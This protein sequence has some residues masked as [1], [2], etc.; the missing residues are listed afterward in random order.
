MPP[1][2]IA[3]QTRYQID[4]RHILS[5]TSDDSS[6]IAV[7]Q[8]YFTKF[9]QKPV[10][11]LADDDIMLLNKRLT[12]DG[13]AATEVAGIF[14]PLLKLSTRAKEAAMYVLNFALEMEKVGKEYFEKL[15]SESTLPGIKNI[16]GM[17][18]DEQQQLYDTF[19]SLQSKVDTPLLVDSLALERAI[20]VFARIFN[21]A[22]IG[23]LKNDLDAYYHAMKIEAEIVTF[24]EDM[25]QKETNDDAR[26]LLREIAAEE[27]KLYDTI[28]TI[29]DFVA[30]PCTH[31][32]WGEFSNLKEL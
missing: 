18:A 11:L 25:A 16:F 22:T 21:E 23:L 31:L 32:A 28:E 30:A 13:D 2:K 7:Y 24:F 4:S 8:H 15:A 9:L 3:S 6:Q 20:D 1:W 12:C 5:K 14:P 29:H 27:K 19:K 10:A 26:T 17:L